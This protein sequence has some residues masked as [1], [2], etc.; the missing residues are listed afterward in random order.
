[1]DMQ[2]PI[3]DGYEATETL[4]KLDYHGPIVAL[5]ASAMAADRARCL[6][7]GCDD[8]ATKPV[9]RRRLL[10]IIRE[11]VDRSRARATS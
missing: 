6:D 1:M 4:R 10:G 9:N 2:M 5:T 7:A 11:Q 8:F 3:M